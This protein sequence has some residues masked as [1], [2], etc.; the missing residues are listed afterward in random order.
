MASAMVQDQTGPVSSLLRAVIRVVTQSFSQ[1]EALRYDPNNG[2][3]GNYL[4]LSPGWGHCMF[5]TKIYSSQ[6]YITRTV[7]TCFLSTDEEAAAL[8]RME[9]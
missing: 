3:E 4:G 7:Y 6:S 5:L 2:C 1:R 8:K 9:V